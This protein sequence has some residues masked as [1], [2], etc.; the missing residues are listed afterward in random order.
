VVRRA[1]ACWLARDR[2]G[3]RRRAA[4]ACF[5]EKGTATVALLSVEATGEELDG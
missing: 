1:S 4:V 3:G 2:M 5:A